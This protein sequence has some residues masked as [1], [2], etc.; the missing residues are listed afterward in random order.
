LLTD[1]QHTMKVRVLDQTGRYTVIE[2]SAVTFTV[3]NGAD[4]TIVGAI[5]S[6][7]NNDTLSGTVTI[8]GYAYSPSQKVIGGLILIDGNTYSGATVR[9]NQPATA[10]CSTLPGPPPQ[11]PNIGF[12]VN[13]DTTHFE[14]GPHILGMLMVNDA[15]Q[16]AIIPNISSTGMNVTIQN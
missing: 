4:T 16:I 8:A 7:K 11:C 5:T 14:N 3:K 10:A 2:D 9:V 12:T 1:G 13:L 15:G 6:P